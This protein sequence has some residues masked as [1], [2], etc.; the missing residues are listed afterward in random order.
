MAQAYSDRE[1]MEAAGLNYFPTGSNNVSSAF[2]KQGEGFFQLGEGEELED[3]DKSRVVWET[4][5]DE[6]EKKAAFHG[7]YKNPVLGKNR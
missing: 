4:P 2:K 3:A 7:A 1:A 6:L 5:F